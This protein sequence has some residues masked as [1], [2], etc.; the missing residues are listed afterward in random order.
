MTVKTDLLAFKTKLVDAR[1]PDLNRAFL[2][3][4]KTA[5]INPK[6]L[7]EALKAS[8]VTINKVKMAVQ[9]QIDSSGGK[10][11]SADQNQETATIEFEAE[12]SETIEAAF[13]AKYLID[14]M[15]YHSEKV[16]VGFNDK[17]LVIRCGAFAQTLMQI[18]I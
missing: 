4:D 16:E 17:Q 18:K 11:I 3:T 14:A 13:N 12:S 1:Y 2:P 8:M 9:I 7:S 5:V 10:V 6:S 15:Q